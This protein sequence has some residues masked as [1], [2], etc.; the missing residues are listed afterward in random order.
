MSRNAYKFVADKMVSD[1]K[2]SLHYQFA[3][4]RDYISQDK[5]TE[6]KQ[7]VKDLKDDKLFFS[8]F[9]IPDIKKVAFQ[10]NRWAL[11]T[12]M[13]VMGVFA[14]FG[15]KVYKTHT[16]ETPYYNRNSFPQL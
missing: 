11:I 4:L 8:F 15:I 9:Y 16:S 6:F 7:D 1:D 14:W 5:L 12:T 3:Y 2:L 13:I 10:L